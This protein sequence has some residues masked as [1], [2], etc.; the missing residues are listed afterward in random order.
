[1]YWFIQKEKHKFSRW[2]SPVR[3]VLANRLFSN[4][5]ETARLKWKNMLIND[6]GITKT[7]GGSKDPEEAGSQAARVG[8]EG[9]E[10]SVR[11]CSTQIFSSVDSKVA[12]KETAKC[13]ISFLILFIDGLGVLTLTR[14]SCCCWGAIRECRLTDLYKRNEY[15]R[16]GLRYGYRTGGILPGYR[17]LANFAPGGDGFPRHLCEAAL[18]LPS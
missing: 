2:T 10:K 7:A 14:C 9:W 4:A 18:C 15:F 11:M 6:T 16:S 17:H 8:Y 1:V 3:Q 12:P 13:C 5:T